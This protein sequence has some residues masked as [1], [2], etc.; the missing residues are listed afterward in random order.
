MILDEFAETVPMAPFSIGIALLSARYYTCLE[1]EKPSLFIQVCAADS[2]LN[3]AKDI[4][5]IVFKIFKFFSEL[6]LLAHYPFGKVD[7]VLTSDY[8]IDTYASYGLIIMR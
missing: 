6:F 8:R 5:E 1:F 2:I 4:H 7:I 3:D